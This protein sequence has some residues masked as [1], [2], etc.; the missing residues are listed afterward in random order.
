MV[1]LAWYP[2]HYYKVSFGQQDKLQENVLRIKDAEGISIETG[3]KEIRG[4]LVSSDNVITKSLLNHFNLTVP[5]WFLS[6]WYRGFNKT[7]IYQASQSDTEKPLYKLH[8]DFIEVYP[9]WFEYL[10]KHSSILRDFCYWNLANFLQVRNPN[11][12]DLT[13]KLIKPA[14][15][16][17]LTKQRKEFWNI[18]LNERPDLQCIYTKKSLTTKNYVVD[19]FIPF[20]FVSHDLIWN[21]IP[22]HSDSSSIKSDKLPSLNLYF[23]SFYELQK[24]AIQI[25]L[26]KKP[27]SEFIKEYLPIFPQIGSECSITE[28]FNKTRLR[29][30]FEPLIKIAHNNGFEY[31]NYDPK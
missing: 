24:T 3:Q 19:H 22:A 13:G 16:K 27:G 23:D 15:R 10:I 31:F 21:L 29:D 9:V 1:A 2:V 25:I 12:P 8:Y 30:T 26:E 7:G 17:P 11:I 20:N 14:V 28:A 6:P 4:L 18:V 5:H